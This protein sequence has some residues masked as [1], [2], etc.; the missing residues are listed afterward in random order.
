[1]DSKLP[2]NAKIQE[3]NK[4]QRTALFCCFLFPTRYFVLSLQGTCGKSLISKAQKLDK[5]PT[6]KRDL[7]IQSWRSR[8]MPAPV[9]GEAQHTHRPVPPV[10]EQDFRASTP[11]SSGPPKQKC[12]ENR[13][14]HGERSS[15][16]HRRDEPCS[17][18]SSAQLSPGDRFLL[19][20]SSGL[21][22]GAYP[23]GQTDKCQRSSR[24]SHRRSQ[25]SLTI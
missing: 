9:P 7:K 13:G 1:M 12:K 8:Q 16:D 10:P 6:D 20:P 24:G 15:R 22:S 14:K 21:A 3:V 5:L 11:K 17:A 18:D 4:S 2:F 23:S 25:S 19:G